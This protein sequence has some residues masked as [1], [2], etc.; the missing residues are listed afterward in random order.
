MTRFDTKNKD[1]ARQ[2]V[3]ENVAFCR[4]WEKIL[5][6]GGDHRPPTDRQKSLAAVP[7]STRWAGLS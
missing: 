4:T 7:G 2:Q 5:A 3:S 1:V 6:V